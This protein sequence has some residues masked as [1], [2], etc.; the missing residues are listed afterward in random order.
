MRKG[1][2]IHICFIN[3]RKVFDK[4][5]R[6]NIWKK[7]ERIS[8]ERYIIKNIK[9]LYKNYKNKVRSLNEEFSE[10]DRK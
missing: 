2:E 8:V 9:A 5:R 6:G 1:K 4:I 10:F 3:L 7:R